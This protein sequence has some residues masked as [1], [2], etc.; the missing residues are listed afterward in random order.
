[1]GRQGIQTGNLEK[2]REVICLVV[3]STDHT[4]GRGRIWDFGNKRGLFAVVH[5]LITLV[6]T[7][8]GRIWDFENREGCLRWYVPQTA[9]TETWLA[10]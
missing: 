9:Y 1:M 3:S 10:G 6:V 2:E 8:R 4:T 7:D 5:P